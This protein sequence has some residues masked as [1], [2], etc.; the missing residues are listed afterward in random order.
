LPTI[1]TSSGTNPSQGTDPSSRGHPTPA[2][3]SSSGLR[4]GLQQPSDK[5]Y[6][7]SPRGEPPPGGTGSASSASHGA[8][9]IRRWS[10]S[11]G[12][13]HTIYSPDTKEGPGSGSRKRLDGSTL[14]SSDGAV[15]LSQ[16]SA[17]VAERLKAHSDFAS[18]EQLGGCRGGEERLRD[19]VS[20]GSARSQEGPYQP[21]SRFAAALR[22][23]A[24]GHATAMVLASCLLL[25]CAG[26]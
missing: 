1:R 4:A 17:D 20:Q 23:N 22:Q 10:P 2:E 8:P 24:S 13:M 14:R 3:P 26:F 18:L 21:F 16:R 9:L 19:S 12:S 25:L 7:L 11:S 15:L 5:P 6:K